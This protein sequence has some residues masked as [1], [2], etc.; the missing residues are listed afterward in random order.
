MFFCI[1]E[2]PKVMV[3]CIKLRIYLNSA[4]ETKITLLYSAIGNKLR[5][6]YFEFC[7]WLSLM[8]FCIKLILLFG[9][10]LPYVA[11]NQVKADLVSHDLLCMLLRVEE[12]SDGV[13]RTFGNL[14]RYRYYENA[15]HSIYEG[16]ANS[17][18]NLQT[19]WG[20]PLFNAGNSLKVLIFANLF[21]LSFSH[22]R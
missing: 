7:E 5:L 13:L 10:R 8:L 21:L 19:I 16:T 2:Q 17:S 20:F 12:Q 22:V 4:L 9:L 1:R 14:A 3:C 11:L 15:F 6:T 18:L